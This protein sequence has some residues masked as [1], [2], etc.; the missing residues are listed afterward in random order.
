[1]WSLYPRFAIE[2]QKAEHPQEQLLEERERGGGNLGTLNR[3]F[4][5]R[6]R[7]ALCVRWESKGKEEKVLGFGIIEREVK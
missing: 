5:E 6:E 7:G 2:S 3:D 4:E 1:M